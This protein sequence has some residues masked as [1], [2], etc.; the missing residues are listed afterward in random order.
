MDQINIILMKEKR[1]SAFQ[2]AQLKRWDPKLTK[3]IYYK[4]V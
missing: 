3:A 4:Y 2:A 1:P